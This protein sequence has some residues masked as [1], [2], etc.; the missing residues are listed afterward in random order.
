MNEW[1]PISTAP[2][3]N[4]DVLV[5]LNNGRGSIFIART[6]GTGQWWSD[7]LLRIPT[8]THWMPLPEP[9][10]TRYEERKA[11][12]VRKLDTPGLGW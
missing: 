1:Q 10:P 7:G 11:N 6:H 5:C 2:P 8:P 4:V 3:N 12:P 9:P